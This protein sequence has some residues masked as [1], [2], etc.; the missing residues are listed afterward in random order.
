MLFTPWSPHLKLPSR[1]RSQ[2]SAYEEPVEAGALPRFIETPTATAARTPM[3]EKFVSDAQQNVSATRGFP[4]NLG[5]L[6]LP[7][8][9][10]QTHQCKFLIYR[11]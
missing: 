11:S 7:L 2:R 5:Q 1:P 3:S 6:L 4:E 8:V 9:Q 10:P